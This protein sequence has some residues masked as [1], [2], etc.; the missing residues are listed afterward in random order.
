VAVVSS[1]MS[2]SP[3]CPSCAVNTIVRLEHTL[4]GTTVTLAWHCL[5]CHTYWAVAESTPRI[6][7]LVC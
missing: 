2:A 5:R 6:R 3:P 1:L 7:L 4:D